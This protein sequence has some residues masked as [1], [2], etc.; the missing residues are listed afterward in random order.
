MRN[1]ARVRRRKS[2]LCVLITERKKFNLND[3]LRALCG[4]KIENAGRAR[5][6]SRKRRRN[7]KSVCSP[8]SFC[9]SFFLRMFSLFFSTPYFLVFI[10]RLNVFRNVIRPDIRRAKNSGCIPRSAML[11]PNPLSIQNAN[12]N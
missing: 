4:K 5:S 8:R 3:T 1:R 9:F 11:S 7:R 12:D 2:A 10:I 6:K